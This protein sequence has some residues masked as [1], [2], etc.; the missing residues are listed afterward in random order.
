MQAI[1]MLQFFYSLKA[2]K[3]LVTPCGHDLLIHALRPPIFRWDLLKVAETAAQLLGGADAA[4][5]NRSLLESFHLGFGPH[6]LASTA[7]TVKFTDGI[8]VAKPRV[9]SQPS[10]Y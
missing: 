4:S 2:N 3:E 8:L 7:P 10:S 1:L 6:H 5:S 9:T